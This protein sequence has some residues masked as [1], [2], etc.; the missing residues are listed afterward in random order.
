MGVGIGYVFAAANHP[1]YIVEPDQA[2][3]DT[4]RRTIADV[5]AD[6]IRRGKLDQPGADTL[7][8]HVQVLRSIHELPDHLALVVESV[9]E[10]L[11]LKAKV[12][13]EIS[14]RSPRIIATNT[15]ALSINRLA[16]EVPNP[17]SFLGMHFFNPVWSLQMVELIRGTATSQQTMTSAL[18]FVSSIRKEPIVVTDSPGFA[19]SRLDL[20]ASLEAMRML[21]D[22]VATA[23]DIDRAMVI[24]YR[25][26]IGPL[27]LSDIVGLDVRLDIACNLAGSLGD[28][29]SPPKILID[30][31]EAGHLG[32]K[33]GRGFFVHTPQ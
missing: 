6:G 22:G 13:R 9:P 17:S 28:R 31:V 5:A 29:Y 32:V 19:T 23:E 8:G 30:L 26:P 3:V 16:Q 10:R 27:R 4:L 33:T 25:H 14:A 24:A 2:Q 1:T 18:A 20:I 12:L 21:E 7:I 11:E 15:S